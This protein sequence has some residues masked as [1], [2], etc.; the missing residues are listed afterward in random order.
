MPTARH[1]TRLCLEITPKLRTALTPTTQSF[2]LL[3]RS[4]SARQP[5]PDAVRGVPL[6]RRCLSVLRQDPADELRR[7]RQLPQPP[8]PRLAIAGGSRKLGDTGA[9]CGRS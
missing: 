2:E 7:L 4:A 6:L 8:C 9:C 5:L 3:S 1:A